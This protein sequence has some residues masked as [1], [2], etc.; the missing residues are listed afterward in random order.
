MEV[1]EATNG[2][3]PVVGASPEVIY[4]IC[5]HLWSFIQKIF[6][7]AIHNQ[8]QSDTIRHNHTQSY[9]I[10]HN[11]TQSYTIIHNSIHNTRQCHTKVPYYGYKLLFVQ[12][13]SPE[14]TPGLSSHYYHHPTTILNKGS[15]GQ[16]QYKEGSSPFP[17]PSPSPS[18]SH[19]HLI[20]SNQPPKTCF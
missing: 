15:Q 14:S 20:P 12:I 16:V 6:T 17:S 7:V 9:T 10:I 5:G 18:P 4:V 1:L 8:T 13:N 2:E 11:H 19:P 3:N